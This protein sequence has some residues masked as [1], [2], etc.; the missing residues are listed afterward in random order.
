[1]SLSLGRGSPR[2]ADV[3]IERADLFELAINLHTAKALGL[4]VPPHLLANLIR[5][6]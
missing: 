2:P 6:S 5:R 1:M 4:T 3:P